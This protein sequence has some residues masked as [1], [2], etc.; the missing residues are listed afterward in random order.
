MSELNLESLEALL[1]RKLASLSP[2]KGRDDTGGGSIEIGKVVDAWRVQARLTK[3]ALANAAG[4]HR[5]YLSR[6]VSGERGLS[7]ATLAKLD[8]VFANDAF[9][10]DVCAAKRESLHRDS[11]RGDEYPPDQPDGQPPD[12]AEPLDSRDGA[13][14][15]ES[16]V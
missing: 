16:A 11:D 5:S 7:L 10:A 4:I 8:E 1:D 2:K 6:I 13:G 14:G 12:E 15:D 9:A 3:Q